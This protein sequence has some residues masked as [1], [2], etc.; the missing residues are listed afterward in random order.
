M[1]SDGDFRADGDV[2][3]ESISVSDRRLKENLVE[4]TPKESLEKLLSL[5]GYEFEWKHKEDG[6]HYG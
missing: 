1:E 6:V 3:A 4:I 5:Q 2:L